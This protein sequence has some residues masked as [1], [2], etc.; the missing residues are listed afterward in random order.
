MKWDWRDLRRFEVLRYTK[1][2]PK[3]SVLPNLAG[4]YVLAN[5]K[6][7]VIYIGKAGAGRLNLE[8][9]SAMNVR[10]KGRGASLIRCLITCSDQKAKSLERYL[11]RKYKP[12]NNIYLK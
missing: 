10:G 8:S 7:V 1:W 4:V 2:S 6:G 5:K 12:R 3:Y 11:I 9:R